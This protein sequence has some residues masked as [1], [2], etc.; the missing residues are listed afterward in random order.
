MKQSEKH[1]Q[2]INEI[3]EAAIKAFSQ[4][5][6]NDISLN[7]FCQ[8]NGILKGKFYHYF[9]SK[10]ELY[11]QCCIYAFKRLT[12]DIKDFTTLP[13][14]TI[15]ENFHRYYERRIDYWK[16]H[17][18]DFYLAYYAM[19]KYNVLDDSALN[20]R[21]YIH[22]ETRK[23]KW[24]EI[25]QNSSKNISASDEDLH[26]ILRTIYDDFFTLYMKKYVQTITNNDEE[27]AN[28]YKEYLLELND[29][30]IRIILYGLFSIDK[31]NS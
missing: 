21:K 15:E 25:F 16:N 9:S 24:K 22:K 8:S 30:M 18:D 13:E 11:F 1:R 31:H 28:Y 4:N 29:K 20:E 14:C 5:Q 23:R 6:S 19:L 17:I 7:K 26:E 27:A 2:S 12:A 10:E 3:L